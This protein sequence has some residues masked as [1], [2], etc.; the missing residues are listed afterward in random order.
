MNICDLSIKDWS[1]LA[2]ATNFTTYVNEHVHPGGF[3]INGR[4]HVRTATG[5]VIKQL[6]AA[7][8][9]RACACVTSQHSNCSGTSSTAN[10]RDWRTSR[11]TRSAMSSPASLRL[12]SSTSLLI[13][14]PDGGRCELPPNQHT[15][16]A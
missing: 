11:G 15:E 3:A 6:S 9:W 16:S 1:R 2:S 5:G 14:N 13:K 4:E 7:E 8:V 12:P 10:M